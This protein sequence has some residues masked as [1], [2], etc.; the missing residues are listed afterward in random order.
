[1]FAKMGF[2]TLY[3]RKHACLL[4]GR[5]L[6]QGVFPQLALARPRVQLR[7]W[8]TNKES[9]INLSDLQVWDVLEYRLNAS[10][11][12][13]LGL[14]RFVEV[15]GTEVVLE[16]LREEE[17]GLWLADSST[18]VLKVPQEALL[19]LVEAEYGQRVDPDRISNPHSEHAEDIWL[20]APTSL[21]Q[22]AVYV[23]RTP[24]Q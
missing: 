19:R 13:N 18:D 24:L 21:S 17:E 16:P 1:M 3:V 15:A 10:G 5:L 14:A 6:S 22:D 7:R 2:R 20:V 8:A 9:V 23:G 11:D 12:N 4:D